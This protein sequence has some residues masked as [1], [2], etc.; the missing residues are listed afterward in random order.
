MIA[1]LMAH[2]SMESCKFILE[3]VGV[4]AVTMMMFKGH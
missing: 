3:T 1:D 2:F 4:M